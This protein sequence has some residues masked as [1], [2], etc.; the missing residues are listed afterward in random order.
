VVR[1]APVKR[2]VGKRAAKTRHCGAR[3]RTNTPTI[4]H[5]SS[6]FGSRVVVGRLSWR[7]LILLRLLPQH[8]QQLPARTQGWRMVNTFR[9]SNPYKP[10]NYAH[11]ASSR[12]SASAPRGLVSA[13]SA[14]RGLSRLQPRERVSSG[15]KTRT[16]T[17]GTGK[18]GGAS[19][20]GS[21]QEEKAA[22]RFAVP[23]SAG[24]AAG[25]TG[26]LYL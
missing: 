24:T 12:E 5:L 26:A 25:G 3:T 22:A 21:Q 10:R 16:G 2:R 20:R 17:V 8:L 18:H 14:A 11:L 6:A 19:A 13:S 15:L 7:R 23:G 9:D 4:A 1:Y